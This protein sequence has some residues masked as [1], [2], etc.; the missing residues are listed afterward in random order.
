MEPKSSNNIE[1]VFI[2]F[3]L[4]TVHGE[5]G[6]PVFQENNFKVSK[7]IWYLGRADSQKTFFVSFCPPALGFYGF[8]FYIDC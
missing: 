4:L 1:N 8:V 2:Y 6:K 7:F 3:V 5:F